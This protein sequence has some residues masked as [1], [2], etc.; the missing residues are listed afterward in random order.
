MAQAVQDYSEEYEWVEVKALQ[1]FSINKR[2]WNN[3]KNIG[4]SKGETYVLPR[5]RKGDDGYAEGMK[6]F[7]ENRG[8]LEVV[9]ANPG[10]LNETDDEVFDC[11]ECGREFDSR[12][13]LSAH[14]RQTHE[15][16]EDE[17]ETEEKVK[18]EEEEE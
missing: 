1:K 12:Q 3:G 15:T 6:H 5:G 11:D 4:L 8:F 7:F 9:D 17:D 13:G 10:V 16:E 2:P 18:N 14:T